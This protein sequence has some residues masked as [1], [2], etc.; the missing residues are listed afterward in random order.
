MGDH[1]TG[2]VVDVD[3]DLHRRPAR[4]RRHGVRPRRLADDH[5]HDVG[6]SGGVGAAG[7]V[8]DR[9]HR[10]RRQ[11]PERRGE[12][13]EGGDTGR[14]RQ[15]EVRVDADGGHRPPGEQGSDGRRR[16]RQGAVGGGD[17]P[18]PDGDRSGDHLVDRQR[19][20]GGGDADD[21]DDGVDGADLVEL[22]IVGI[23]AVDRA[24][25]LGERVEHRLGTA[26]HAF[27]QV[28]AAEQLANVTGGPV[29]VAVPG[30]FDDDVR[31]RRRHAAA[32]HTLERQRVA[33]DAEPG[34]GG[35]HGLAVGAGVDEG[36]EQHVA[37]DAGAALRVG[38]ATVPAGHRRARSILATAHAAP[39]PL[40]TPTTVMPLAHDASIASSA[41]TPSSDEP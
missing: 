15:L 6:S 22:D 35:E 18:R 39:K 17:R 2:D 30:S 34:E 41:V 26:A 5:L 27:G 7:A 3:V 8:A 25:G 1:L 12:G 33:V 28:G 14:R 4:R 31:P 38:D 10:H 16:V 19:L 23:D 21:V 37:G 24:L 36:A 20:E 11:R 40:S 32:L 29:L 13:G 9:R